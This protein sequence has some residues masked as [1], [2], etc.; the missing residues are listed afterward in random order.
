[1]SGQFELEPQETVNY[2]GKS[3]LLAQ[4]ADELRNCPDS[5][6]AQNVIAW[7]NA[8]YSA[9]SS[10]TDCSYQV[11]INEEL[12]PECPDAEPPSTIEDVVDIL[13]GFTQGR[14]RRVGRALL[15]IACREA[16]RQQT[17]NTAPNVS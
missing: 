4:I 14:P 6:F 13:V 12:C 17:T 3:D 16:L 2:W 10:I 7:Y 9:L 8:E 15:R 5:C 11:R 1:M